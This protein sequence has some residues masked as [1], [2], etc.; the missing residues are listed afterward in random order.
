MRSLSLSSGNVKSQQVY[1]VIFFFI[2]LRDIFNSLLDINAAG[3][4]QETKLM[5]THPTHRFSHSKIKNKN[6]HTALSLIAE[7]KNTHR[8]HCV[9]PHVMLILVL[10]FVRQRV[11]YSGR[12]VTLC[13]AKEICPGLNWT[14]SFFPLLSSSCVWSCRSFH[15]C[16]CMNSVYWFHF[17]TYLQ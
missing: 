6:T 7:A 5:H 15:P 8:S 10:R 9:T 16:I 11:G 4:C 2:A 14:H 1:G 12:D 13:P 17:P 3:F